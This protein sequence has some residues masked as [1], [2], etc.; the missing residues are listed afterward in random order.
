MTNPSKAPLTLPCLIEWDEGTKLFVGHC[1]TFDLVSTSPR[2]SREAF[3]N[4][5][6]LIKLHIEYSY[7]HH[8][9]GLSVTADES[10][11]NR[12]RDLV[13]SGKVCK[14]A[15]EQIEV[16]LTEPWNNPTFWADV[17]FT[18]EAAIDESSPADLCASR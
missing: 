7:T 11:W 12:W 18:E 1:L 3:D 6:H 5:K 4:L 10:E 13:N 16:T 14:Q 8:Q 2:A 9:A 15:V 17:K